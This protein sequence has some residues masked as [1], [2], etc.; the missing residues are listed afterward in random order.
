MRVIIFPV[1]LRIPVEIYAEGCDGLSVDTTAARGNTYMLDG[2][3]ETL[4]VLGFAAH[5][6]KEAK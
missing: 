4:K 6:K 2:Y 5:Q 1:K 3:R